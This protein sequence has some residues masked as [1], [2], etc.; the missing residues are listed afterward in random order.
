MK[1]KEPY[2]GRGM[3]IL[4]RIKSLAG[5]KTTVAVGTSAADSR[6]HSLRQV[7]LQKKF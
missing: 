1:S 4:S 7:L 2:Q 3:L 5:M 6:L